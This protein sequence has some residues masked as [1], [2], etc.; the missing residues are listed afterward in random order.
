[1]MTMLPTVHRRG[2]RK[3]V[4]GRP[5]EA[6][7]KLRAHILDDVPGEASGSIDFDLPQNCRREHRVL[8][9][10]DATDAG[11]DDS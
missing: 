2:P 6:S 11:D 5:W 1:M 7:E 9:D 8:N 4:R 3:G 10:A